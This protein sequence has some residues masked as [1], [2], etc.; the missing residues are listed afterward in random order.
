MLPSFVFRLLTILNACSFAVELATSIKGIICLENSLKEINGP[1]QHV[2]H[3]T[4]SELEQ[5]V[6]NGTLN[7]RL[8]ASVGVRYHGIPVAVFLDSANVQD[9]DIHKS[10]GEN[11]RFSMTFA[12]LDYKVL[13]LT[14]M[15]L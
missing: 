11:L 4:L 15:C 2:S 12:P 14:L 1:S 6:E 5:P 3:E 10:L 13:L 8:R 7:S 9:K